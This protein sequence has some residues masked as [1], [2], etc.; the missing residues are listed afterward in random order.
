MRYFQNFV[1]PKLI[2]PE[3]RQLIRIINIVEVTNNSK[4][5]TISL[6][7]HQDL[8]TD[9]ILNYITN[10]AHILALNK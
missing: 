8:R 3:I 10:Q 5:G 6:L 1:L 2:R 4:M 9:H 7:L